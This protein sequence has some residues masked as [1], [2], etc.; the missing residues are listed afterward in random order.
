MTEPARRTFKR[1]HLAILVGTVG[2]LA[3]GT[4][5]AV[6]LLS[7]RS[8]PPP[9]AQPTVGAKLASIP[10]EGMFC[11]S[12]AAA[13]KQKVKSLDGVRDAE[14][15]LAEKLVVVNYIADRPDVPARAAAAIDSL[16]YRAG[17]PTT[18]S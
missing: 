14:V 10:V 11:L 9:A 6:P 18:H 3:I 5:A 13:I 7:S 16:G 15:H 12:C 1:S 4:V 17:T 2:A 8:A